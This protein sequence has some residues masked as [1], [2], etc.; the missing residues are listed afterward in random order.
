[1][2]ITKSAKKALR[3]SVARKYHNLAYKT[4]MKKLVK[5]LRALVAGQKKEEAKKLL[6]SVYKILDKS[7]KENVIKA[8]TASRLKSR[9]SKSIANLDSHNK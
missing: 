3:Q 4:K 5:E 6:P 9:L 8:N 1:M 7:A 2:A